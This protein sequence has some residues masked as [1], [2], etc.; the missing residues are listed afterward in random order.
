MICSSVYQGNR[1]SAIKL[2]LIN[3]LDVYLHNVRYYIVNIHD[4]YNYKIVFIK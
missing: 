1:H 3:I 2:L 4:H